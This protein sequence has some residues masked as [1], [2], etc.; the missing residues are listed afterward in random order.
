MKIEESYLYLRGVLDQARDA[1]LQQLEDRAKLRQVVKKRNIVQ[2]EG[3]E[4]ALQYGERLV[5]SCSQDQVDLLQPLVQDRL[6]NMLNLEQGCGEDQNEGSSSLLWE[7]G[8]KDIAERALQVRITY[9]TLYV[10]VH[11]FC[12]LNAALS[13]HQAAMGAKL[14]SSITV[15][16]W[17]SSLVAF[18]QIPLCCHLFFPPNSTATTWQCSGYCEKAA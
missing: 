17:I 18:S 6:L 11:V 7:A 2:Q 10:K 16:S 14:A 12:Q 8:D 5:A 3:V 15:N 1:A 4:A 13:S 9:I